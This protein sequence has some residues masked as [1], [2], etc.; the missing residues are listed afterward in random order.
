MA[1][2]CN[3]S[4][5]DRLQETGEGAEGEGGREGVERRADRCREGGGLEASVEA[6]VG[7]IRG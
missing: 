2:R 1:R 3:I 4:S 5:V 7:E 6:S